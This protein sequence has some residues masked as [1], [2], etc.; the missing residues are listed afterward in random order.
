MTVEGVDA[1]ARPGGNVKVTRADWLALA[2][3][4][5]IEDGV[6]EVKV[7]TLSDRLGV[8]RSSFYWYFKSR[9]DL[10]DALLADWEAGN[11]GV[12]V[13][14]ADMAAPTITAAVCNLFRCFVDPALF[15]YRL[16][17]AVREWARRDGHVR[18]VIDQGDADRRIAL[19]RMFERFGYAPYEADTRARILYFMQVG[20]YALDLSESL[21]ERLARVE[22]YILGFTGQEARP[23]EIAELAAYA[24]EVHPT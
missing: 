23:G 3:D 13:R 6:G 9:A 16:D 14:H 21:D 11:T 8:S 20:Y 24:R 22:G 7:L 2:R 1:D 4:V 17:F 12:L 5:L 10:L 15:N 18:H 19:T